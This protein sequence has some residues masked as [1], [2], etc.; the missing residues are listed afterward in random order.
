MGA[1]QATIEGEI[2]MRFVV[3]LLVAFGWATAAHAQALQPGDTISISVYQ[4][5]RL[6]RQIMIGPT[7]FISMP[8][9]GQIRAGG[10][11]PAD[12]ENE[13]K[14]RL[15]D[16]FSSGLDVSVT[17]VSSKS[18]DDELKPRIFV[19]GEV[20]RPGFYILRQ[21]TTLL[22]AIALSGGLGPFAARSR[23]QVRR[24]VGGE[25]QVFYFNYRGFENGRDLTGNIRLRAGDVVVV[26][27]RGL[28]ELY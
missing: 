25:E 14:S 24:T 21:P 2:G 26:P 22:Q 12:L 16:K 17:L 5:S 6:D 27:E 4:D 28:F 11:S 20:S 18:P 3:A 1:A 10:M 15:K 13:I 8:L 23:I 9:A 7:G 19:T